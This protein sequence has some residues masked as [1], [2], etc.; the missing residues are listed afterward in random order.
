MTTA[1]VYFGIILVLEGPAPDVTVP[2][3]REHLCDSAT[4]ESRP[5]ADWEYIEW[6]TLQLIKGEVKIAPLLTPPPNP[7]EIGGAKWW[8]FYCLGSSGGVEMADI[9]R[10]ATIDPLL[11]RAAFRHR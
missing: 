8:L 1:D 2:K 5:E 10:A 6:M 4:G 9:G 3:V 11:I 7:S